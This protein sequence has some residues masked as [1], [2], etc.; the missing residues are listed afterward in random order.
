MVFQNVQD[1]TVM[2]MFHEFVLFRCRFFDDR[3]I[4]VLW[5]VGEV[6]DCERNEQH[7]IGGE[8]ACFI[9][10]DMFHLSQVFINVAIL[11]SHPLQSLQ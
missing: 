7:V 1:V 11:K 3:S 10:K 9:W 4:E 8:S 6:A 2:E 5:T